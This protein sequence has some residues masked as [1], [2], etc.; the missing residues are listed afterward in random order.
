MYSASQ[1]SLNKRLTSGYVLSLRLQFVLC[2]SACICMRLGLSACTCIRLCMSVVCLRS[3][4][5]TCSCEPSTVKFN[6]LT[7][8]TLGQMQAIDTR[9]RPSYTQDLSMRHIQESS[10]ASQGYATSE[11]C[12]L[13]GGVSDQVLIVFLDLEKL[14]TWNKDWRGERLKA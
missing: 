1:K 13:V 10:K 2:S 7:V 8:F 9:Y 11:R 4:V 5:C 6:F 3:H 12:R 14:P